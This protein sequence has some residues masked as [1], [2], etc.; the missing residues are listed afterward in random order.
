[1]ATLTPTQLIAPTSTVNAVVYY[2]SPA[3]T[4]GLVRSVIAMP[5]ASIAGSSTFT[6]CIGTDGATTRI[7]A[8][9]AIVANVPS[10]F[11]MWQLT[12]QN[13]ANACGVSGSD[14]TASH[15]V[16]SVGGYQLA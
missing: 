11:N 6:F 1:M 10:F 8:A 4:N 14:N 5:N 9:V 2:T 3:A 7:L 12:A 15:L 13:S 16:S